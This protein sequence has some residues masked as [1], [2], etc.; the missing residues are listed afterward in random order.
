VREVEVKFRVH[1]PAALL[2]ALSSRGIE[3]G[4]PVHQDDQA[5]APDGW[6]YGEDRRGVPFAR[7]RTVD[8]EHLFTVKRPA[9]QG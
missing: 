6:S 5:Y 3:L 1:D 4:P 7:L 8:G 2:S 9:S